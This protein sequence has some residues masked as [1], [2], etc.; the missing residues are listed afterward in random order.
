[1]IW[2]KCYFQMW[3]VNLLC[4]FNAGTIITASR[5]FKADKGSS[6]RASHQTSSFSKAVCS[7]AVDIKNDI[8][9]H[10]WFCSAGF[11][12]CFDEVIPINISITRLRFNDE[13]P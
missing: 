3:S 13:L 7:T 12:V 1:M 10:A 5:L 8:L 11:V 9:I 2:Q 4:F 6:T